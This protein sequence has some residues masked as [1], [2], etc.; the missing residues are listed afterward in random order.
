[1]P[2]VETLVYYRIDTSELELNH[3]N[4]PRAKS[5]ILPV[6]IVRWFDEGSELSYEEFNNY[7]TAL[8][9]FNKIKKMEF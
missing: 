5:P 4:Y 1:M 8:K 3:V 6:Y 9:V 2:E 7:D